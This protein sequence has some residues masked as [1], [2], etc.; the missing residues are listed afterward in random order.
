MLNNVD[1]GT[2]LEE[3]FDKITDEEGPIEPDEDDEEN[4]E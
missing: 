4:D 2:D 3:E 1:L